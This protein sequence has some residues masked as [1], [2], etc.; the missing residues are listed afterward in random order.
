MIDP[1]SAMAHG[2]IRGTRAHDG[3][4]DLIGPPESARSLANIAPS[5][6]GMP[7]AGRGGPMGKPSVKDLGPWSG[8]HRNEPD[9]QRTED[10]PR[11][12]DAV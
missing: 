7:I 3:V 5:A 8:P 2:S 9:G 1:T 12:T 10:Q 4:D 11:G 6:I